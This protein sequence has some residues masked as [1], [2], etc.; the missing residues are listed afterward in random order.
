[1]KSNNGGGSAFP[2]TLDMRGGMSLRDY[3]AA[4]VIAA[5][6]ASPLRQENTTEQDAKYAYRI[7]DD[8]LKAREQTN[9]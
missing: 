3:F 6:C 9:A 2:H 7:A 4:S 8:M 1:M 5:L